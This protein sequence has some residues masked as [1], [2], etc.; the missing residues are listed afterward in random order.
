MQQ[1]QAFEDMDFSRTMKRLVK[2]ANYLIRDNHIAEE[3]AQD[4]FV[5]LLTAG[6]VE[7]PEAFLTTVIFRVCIDYMRK[8]RCRRNGI[9]LIAQTEEQI[10]QARINGQIY[11][12][13]MEA[14]RSGIDA[15]PVED[16]NIANC[17][18]D[19]LTY[20]QIAVL[21]GVSQNEVRRRWRKVKK[22]ICEN[23]ESGE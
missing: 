19:G 14:V 20:A 4:A 1:A 5:R 10:I 9:K 2:K 3:L 16:R 7:K 8:E 12:E 18:L 23:L 13:K 6:P 22:L 15:L 21:T 11:W 17:W